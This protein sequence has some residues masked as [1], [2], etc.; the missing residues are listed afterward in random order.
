MSKVT[1]DMYGY[2]EQIMNTSLYVYIPTPQEALSWLEQ[3][4]CHLLKLKQT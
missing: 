1:L 3:G 4:V 2:D